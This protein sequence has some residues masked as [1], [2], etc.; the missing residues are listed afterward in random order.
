MATYIL[1]KATVHQEHLNHRLIFTPIFATGSNQRS[2]ST[3]APGRRRRDSITT[4]TALGGL[5][6]CACLVL[7][8]IHS[9]NNMAETPRGLSA[10]MMPSLASGAIKV[11]LKTI[12]SEGVTTG[13]LS[14]PSPRRWGCMP[15]RPLRNPS[16][17]L[18]SRLFH[19][20][21]RLFPLCPCNGTRGALILFSPLK[22]ATT[23]PWRTCAIAKTTPRRPSILFNS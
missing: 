14:S 15:P 5:L 10:V 13:R 18:N 11:E 21:R 6:L 20:P 17:S 16:L 19:Q 1:G 7:V 4:N 22:P 8:L 3:M 12:E 23:G 2:L 9:R